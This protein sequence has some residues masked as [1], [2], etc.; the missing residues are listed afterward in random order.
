M[1]GETVSGDELTTQPVGYACGG[2]T[3]AVL[4]KTHEMTTGQLEAADVLNIGSVPS[5][6]IFVDGFIATDDLDS[7]GTPTLDLIVGTSDDEDGLLSSGTAGQ[8]AAVT[9]FNGAFLTD[10]TE[11][12]AQTN[13]QV[14]ANAAAATAVAGTVRVVVQY[15]TPDA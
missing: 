11:T 4:D 10:R 2:Y 1:A 13:I 14:K 15:Y 8:A 3:L 5:G 9:R 6:A 12:T 7:N